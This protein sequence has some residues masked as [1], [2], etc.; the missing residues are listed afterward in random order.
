M[1]ML[2]WLS[3]SSSFILSKFLSYIGLW[4]HSSSI[5]LFKWILPRNKDTPHQSPNSMWSNWPWTL[6][7]TSLSLANFTHKYIT[8]N[9]NFPALSLQKAKLYFYTN[10][11]SP[12]WK[13]SVVPFKV[14]HKPKYKVYTK[15]QGIL[16]PVNPCKIKVLHISSTQ[17]YKYSL[18]LVENF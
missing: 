6:T 7:T 8:L 16:L 4:P 18:F 17:W 3:L 5:I 15:V 2:R 13:V 11:T 12:V 1:S 9:H 10:F 14:I